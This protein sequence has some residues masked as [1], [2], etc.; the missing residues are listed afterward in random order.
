MFAGL[1]SLAATDPRR[2]REML[3]SL[4]DS[5]CPHLVELLQR[6]SLPGEGR[7]RQLIANTALLR[8]DQQRFASEFARWLDLETD[9]FTRRAL[10][11]ALRGTS[12]PVPEPVKRPCLVD[13][14]HV[15]AYR[16]VGERV[17]HQ[18]RNA[19]MDPLGQLIRLSGLIERIE[20]AATRT[21]IAAQV[22]AL[23]DTLSGFG[24]LIELDSGD[25][26]FLVRS[27]HLK[28]WLQAFN[29]EY[30]RK[31]QQIQ[32][33][34][35]KAPE[36]TRIQ[37]TDFLLGIVFWNLWINAQQAV[38]K[39][40]KLIVHIERVTHN[41]ELTIVDSGDGFPPEIGVAGFPDAKPRP[42][43]RGRGLLEIQEAVERL[44]GDAGL[45]RYS[46]GSY[47]VRLRFPLEYP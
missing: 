5:D 37:A 29:D 10:E 3:S 28:D 22:A 32:M 27:I 41:L 47:R 13:P 44:H 15:D 38:G 12:R 34:I 11:A 8:R 17:K 33:D 9:E 35:Q 2:A 16:Y 7:L 21:A 25:G 20:D 19:L 24:R 45:I 39:D 36:D 26:H 42:G 23:K 1:R 4:L 43:H 6:A 18:L 30:G 46:D 31:F 14:A 40:C